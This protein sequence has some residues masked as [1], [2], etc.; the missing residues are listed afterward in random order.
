M[1]FKSMRVAGWML[2]MLCMA[3]ASPAA[4]AQTDSA[5]SLIYIQ[6]EIDPIFPGG[7][8]A[9]FKYIKDSIKYPEGPRDS[10]IQGRVVLRFIVNKDGTLSEATV[11]RRVH[12][13]LDAEAL[14][15]VRSMPPW[16][17]GRQN[18]QPVQVRYTLPIKFILE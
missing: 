16:I 15:V 3:A 1:S 13:A 12:P 17:P 10:G 4:L 14:R 9:L 6:S 2:F 18:G 5:A 11:V 7:D 8:K